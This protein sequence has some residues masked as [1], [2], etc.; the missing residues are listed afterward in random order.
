MES[1][2]GSIPAQGSALKLNS[3]NKEDQNHIYQHKLGSAQQLKRC[4]FCGE[5]ANIV[6]VS[7]SSYKVSC[8][9]CSAEMYPNQVSDIHDPKKHIECINLCVQD[10]NQRVQS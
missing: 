7:S 5:E 6:E 9:G 8:E 10:W 2:A 3:M 4:P 1:R